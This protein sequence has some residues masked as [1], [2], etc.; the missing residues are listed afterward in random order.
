[1]P[2]FYLK[3]R[4]MGTFS[5]KIKTPVH[6]QHHSGPIHV[7]TF[8]KKYLPSCEDSREVLASDG[9]HV[10]GTMHKINFEIKYS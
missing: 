5:A 3:I 4:P 1:M 8:V 6:S 10:I 7:I 2:L 9:H